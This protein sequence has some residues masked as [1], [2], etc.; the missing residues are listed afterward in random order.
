MMVASALGF[1]NALLISNSET[2]ASIFAAINELRG[3]TTIFMI[4][5]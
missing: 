5:H 4:A 1:S 2:E 3:S